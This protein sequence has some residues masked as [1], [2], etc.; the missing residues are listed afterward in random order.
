MEARNS[1]NAELQ[2]A[3]KP[4]N[5]RYL[6]KLEELKKQLTF[7]GDIRGAV[8]VEDVITKM[9]DG[10]SLEQQGDKDPQELKE[11]KKNYMVELETAIKPVRS[12]HLAK[13]EVL[14]Q[15]LALSGA[16]KVALAVEQEMEKVKA[17][18]EKKPR[19]IEGHFFVRAYN[20]DDLATIIVNEQKIIEV[21]F[22]NDSSWVE[23][24]SYLHSGDNLIKFILD[25]FGGGYTYS[26]QLKHDQTILWKN[27]CGSAGSRGCPN[28]KGSPHAYQKE[29]LLTID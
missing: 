9:S 20:I 16:L 3:I 4:V 26:F 7:K 15:Q 24:N 10:Q 18:S 2:K 13:L 1:Y 8:A 21:G 27:E 11:I 17:E 22:R 25:D 19:N 29:Y 23:I 28:P 6:P 12:L 14:K 5:D